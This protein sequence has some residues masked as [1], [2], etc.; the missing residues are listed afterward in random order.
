[1]DI[2]LYNNYI[3]MKLVPYKRTNF[4]KYSTFIYGVRVELEDWILVQYFF[5]NQTAVVIALSKK[6]L[7]SIN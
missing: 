2:Y 1:M 7:E 5:L 6:Y 4:I 3:Q